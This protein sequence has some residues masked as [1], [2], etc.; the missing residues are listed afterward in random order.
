MTGINDLA[1]VFH[2]DVFCLPT[3]PPDFRAWLICPQFLWTD[4]ASLPKEFG[5]AFAESKEQMQGVTVLKLRL[6]RFI[7]TG[8]TRVE[9][10]ASTNS[11]MVAAEAGYEAGRADWATRSGLT[12]WQQWVDWGELDAKSEPTLPLSIALADVQ[13]KAAYAAALE[14]DWLAYEQAQAKAA[15]SGAAMG[16]DDGGMMMLMRSD[17]CETNEFT[18]LA[19]EADEQGRVRVSWCGASNVVYQIQAAPEMLTNPAW[20]A[21]VLIVGEGYSSW[22]DTNA[23]AFAHRF[24]RCRAMRTRTRMGCQ[25]WPSLISAPTS[26]IQTPMATA[27]SM[28]TR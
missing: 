14:A 25:T 5:A 15:E 13:H 11:W 26:T 27:S 19:V 23:P 17:P 9:L 21:Q 7:L 6:T 18:I 10:P 2:R 12:A 20:T 1:R 28:V 3:V 24:Y 4:F 22:T 8:E 16:N